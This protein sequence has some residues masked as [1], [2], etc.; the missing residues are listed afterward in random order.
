MTSDAP[1]AHLFMIDAG[2]TYDPGEFVRRQHLDD[3]ETGREPERRRN[4]TG[5]E[6]SYGGPDLFAQSGGIDITQQAA[7]Q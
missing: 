5:G 1:L 4:L 3:C 2:P 6:P 7:I